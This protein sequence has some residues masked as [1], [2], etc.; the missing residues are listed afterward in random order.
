VCLR[1]LPRCDG[2]S[3]RQT[4]D[5]GAFLPALSRIQR[6]TFVLGGEA[7]PMIPIEC[8]DDLAAALP[9]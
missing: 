5:P 1:L 9:P 7:D 6:P 4:P 3:G 8:Q 2:S